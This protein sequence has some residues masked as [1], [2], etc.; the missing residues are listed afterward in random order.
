[1][2]VPRQASSRKLYTLVAYRR[3][4]PQ[5]LATWALAGPGNMRRLTNSAIVGKLWLRAGFDGGRCGQHAHP[6]P[7]GNNASPKNHAVHLH[8][9]GGT[10]RDSV[11]VERTAAACPRTR[12]DREG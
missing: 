4:G 7:G 8:R 11:D 2:A 1:M 3:G 6:F 10:A 12:R 9:C 5:R